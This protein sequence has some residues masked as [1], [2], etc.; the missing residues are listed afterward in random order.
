[1][2]NPYKQ[3]VE[4]DSQRYTKAMLDGNT[5]ICIAIEE[6]YG[7]Y[8]LPPQQVQEGLQWIGNGGTADEFLEALT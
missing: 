2:T 1:M 3:K 4:A 8:G 5:A 6:D 7:L